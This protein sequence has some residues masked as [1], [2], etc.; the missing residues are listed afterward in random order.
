[1]R[2]ARIAFRILEEVLRE[3]FDEN[4]YRR[5]LARTRSCPSRESYAAFLHELEITRAQ[6]PRCC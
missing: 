3:I 6:R 2:R 4:A 5:Y 1:M